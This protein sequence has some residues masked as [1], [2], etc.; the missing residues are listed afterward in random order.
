MLVVANTCSGPLTIP[1]AMNLSLS[2][3]NT[4]TGGEFIL[5]CE[6]GYSASPSNG[7]LL[8]DESG[9]WLNSASCE[10]KAF[11]GFCTCDQL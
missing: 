6:D 10:G 2:N 9:V 8:C 5:I 3:I 4:A 1:H 7:T 11:V